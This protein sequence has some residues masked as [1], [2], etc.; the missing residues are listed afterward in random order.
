[1]SFWLVWLSALVWTTSAVPIVPPPPERFSTTAVWP[2][3]DWRCAAS[4][5]PMTSVEPP[6]AAGTMMRMFSVGF[7][8][9][10]LDRGRIAA[11]DRPAAPLSTQRR[12]TNLLGQSRGTIHS[13]LLDLQR[14]Y[15]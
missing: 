13:L 12:D 8:S 10:R 3:A 7:Q 2:H 5:R 14:A 15:G 9:A 4:S 6:A 1:M 11:A